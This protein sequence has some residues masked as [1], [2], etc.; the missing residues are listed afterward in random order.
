MVARTG[1]LS[2]FIPTLDEHVDAA[3]R[4]VLG[5]PSSV[6]WRWHVQAGTGH[7]R[8][9][10]WLAQRDGGELSVQL[11]RGGEG[12][13]RRDD[14]GVTTTLSYRRDPGADDPWGNPEQRPF[15]EAMAQSFLSADPA[16]TADLWASS[17]QQQ[18]FSGLRDDMFRQ[19]NGAGDDRIGNLR[20]GFACNQDCGFCWQGRRWPEPQEHY[21]SKWL[22]ELAALGVTS[23]AITGGEPTLHLAL[24]ELVR[25]A[26]G[27]LGLDVSL[28]TNAIELA[29]PRKLKALV[30]AGLK[31]IFVSLHAMEA[32]LSDTITRAPGTWLRTTAGIDAALAAG[33]SVHL[34]CVV[35]RRNAEHLAVLAEHIVARWLPADGPQVEGVTFS[36]PCMAYDP[37]V[38]RDVSA[39]Y[40][41]I[42]P[43]LVAALRS[44]THHGARCF[45]L[46]TCG[47]AACMLDGH[48]DLL[49]AQLRASPPPAATDETD[50]AGRTYLEPCD[51]CAIRTRCLGVRREHA[52]LH[53]P[54][55]LRPQ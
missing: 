10:V 50:R 1:A 27:E 14:D 26:E 19:V 42:R 29:K 8:I 12:R 49:H 37:A 55:E 4:A 2:P 53:G 32:G 54:G 45:A 21:Y 52:D 46:S 38:F 36:S 28:Q 48:D 13:W 43:H 5:A 31:R 3:L 16:K 6:Q 23:I 35:D 7:P 18:R 24:P 41:M 33:L 44:L 30:D 47:F 9:L 51:G 25:R 39:P 15:L 34:N 20:L 40:A 22:D 17:A 11:E